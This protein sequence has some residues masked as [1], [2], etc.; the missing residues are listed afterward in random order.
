MRNGGYHRVDEEKKKKKTRFPVFFFTFRFCAGV[1]T[2]KRET[3][4][5]HTVSPKNVRRNRARKV[6]ARILRVF[7]FRLE[8]TPPGAPTEVAAR[9][10]FTAE[11]NRARFE[12]T[13]LGRRPRES[14]YLK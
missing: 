10:K 12:R 6:D 9:V 5:F 3:S 4:T 1:D 13:C 8:R 2:R 7:V 11:K 14:V